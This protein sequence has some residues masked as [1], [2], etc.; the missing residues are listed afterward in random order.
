MKE[1]YA[2]IAMAV[3]FALSTFLL[4]IKLFVVKKSVKE[5]N[6]QLPRLIQ[7]DTNSLINVSSA[8]KE[9]KK[10]ACSLNTQL[11]LLRENELTYLNGD[12][13]LKSAITNVAHDIR[14]PLT[15]ICG[16][17][18]MIKEESDPE[19]VEKY[20][21]IMS[22]RASALKTLSEELFKYSV[23]SDTSKAKEMQKI[24]VN[25]LLQETLFSFYTRFTERDIN[26]N[27]NICDSPVLR[28][29]DKNSL[30]RIFSNIIDNAIKYGDGNFS[31]NMTD[32]GE[33]SFSNAT[34]NLD[35]VNV[36]KLFDR[37]YTVENCDYSTGLGL[38][39]AKLLTKQIGGKISADLNKNVLTITLRI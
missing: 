39:I 12:N 37:F 8:D 2:I 19:K 6:A 33:I 27:V 25:L 3:F 5:I 35:S 15:A 28:I 36:N 17:L 22:E 31:V 11:R 21:A 30:T 14:T 9:L 1:L 10:L 4:S 20:L 29:T 24:N 38:S 7:G 13:E 32:D 16:Y 18:E 34:S 23:A 26:P